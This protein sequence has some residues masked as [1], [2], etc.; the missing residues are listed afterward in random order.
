MLPCVTMI[1]L[2]HATAED[3]ILQRVIKYTL[4]KWPI[5]VDSESQP[6][7]CFRDEFSTDSGLLLRG[8]KMVVPT[9]IQQRL[10]HFAHENHFGISK[11]KARLRHSY[12]WPGMDKDVE[13]L[14][15]H[16]FCCQQTPRDSPVQ[17]TDWETTPWYHLSMDIAGPKRDCKGHTFYIIALIDD[18][19]RYVVAQVIQSIRTTDIIQFLS[20]TF[21]YFEF[22]GKLTTDNGVQFTSAEFAEYLR[23]YGIAHIRSAVYNPQAN[24]SIE[25]V[26]KNF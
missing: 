9:S 25:R 15:H 13:K 21:T 26:N 24:G 12:W 6:Y 11:S 5:S 1:E 23:L 14:V 10:L 20:T 7:F 4:T 19:S 3:P 17:V 2:S 16:C 8:D 22:C 18:H